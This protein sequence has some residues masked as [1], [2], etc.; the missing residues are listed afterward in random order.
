MVTGDL[1]GARASDLQKP[2]ADLWEA[3]SDDVDRIRHHA[4]RRVPSS[5][6][7][8]FQPACSEGHSA[9][10]CGITKSIS[11]NFLHLNQ[12]IPVQKCK[13]QTDSWVPRNSSIRH[14]MDVRIEFLVHLHAFCRNFHKALAWEFSAWHTAM[15]GPTWIVFDC[16]SHVPTWH[17]Q[18]R[19]QNIQFAGELPRLSCHRFSPLNSRGMTLTQHFLKLK[20]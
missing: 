13:D 7:A 9:K 14:P 4:M 18:G 5:R 16:F 6:R 1:Q 12:A 17:L 19:Q 3:E 2:A 20:K 15:Y 11:E 10:S 8:D